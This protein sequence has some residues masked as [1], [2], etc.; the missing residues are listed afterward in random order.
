MK[1]YLVWNAEA[2]EGVVF[3]DKTDATYAATG[4]DQGKFSV[5][6]L[7]WR[8]RDHACEEDDTTYPI[9]EIEMPDTALVAA[10]E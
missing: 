8:W 2:G 5:C 7:A 1:A 3:D 9:T 4:D 6:T 10:H